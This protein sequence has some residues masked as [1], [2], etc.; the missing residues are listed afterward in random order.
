MIGLHYNKYLHILSLHRIPQARIHWPD[1]N[2]KDS[3]LLEIS[4]L[5]IRKKSRN[6][7]RL[8]DRILARLS[9]KSNRFLRIKVKE[10][11]SQAWGHNSKPKKMLMLP[12]VSHPSASKPQNL[13]EEPSALLNKALVAPSSANVYKAHKEPIISWAT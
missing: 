3:R 7:N 10:L 4:S 12:S 11:W 1:Q 9:S 6:K 2:P 8:K 5:K 13:E